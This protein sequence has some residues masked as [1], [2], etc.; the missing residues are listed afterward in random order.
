[1]N[2]HGFSTLLM[3]A[4]IYIVV[5]LTAF[6]AAFLLLRLPQRIQKGEQAQA[7]IQML[8]AMRRPFLAIKQAEI[9]LVQAVDVKGDDAKFLGAIE[10]ATSLLERYRHL[11]QYH[12]ELSLK[13]DQLSKVFE[14]WIRTERHIIAASAPGAD[15]SPARSL[16]RDHV[17]ANSGFMST[18][19]K[20]GDG[21]VPIHSDI[22]DGR[23]AS[24]QLQALGAALLV[25]LT[26]LAILLQRKKSR[27]EEALLKER[28]HAEKEA[29]QL[30]RSL[31]DALAKV[32]S[33]YISICASC[34]QVLG[35]DGK[36]TPVEVYVTDETDVQFSHGVCPDCTERLY[37]EYLPPEDHK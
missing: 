18:M 10:S 11:A 20:L 4:G 25:Y 23:K 22:A 28:L 6:S 19:E 26:G 34:K 33:G 7:A 15:G 1:M 35:K 30:E 37:G 3:S 32:L 12:P 2:T 31:R 5:G 9:Q 13:V 17:S 21:E 8:D 14:E 29:R 36:W 27:R 16:V 24:H